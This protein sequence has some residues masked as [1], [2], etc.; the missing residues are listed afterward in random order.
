MTIYLEKECETGFPF[1]EEEVLRLVA[2]K[3]AESENC[4]FSCE[5]S[6]TITDNE[7]IRQLNR[8]FR[9]IDRPT[10]VL[11]FP[12]QEYDS[13]ADFSGFS[14]D[15]PERFDPDSG[16]LMLGDIVISAEKVIEQAQEYGH[17]AKREFAFLAAHSM[18]HLFGYDHMTPEE[19]VVMEEKQEAILSD[20]GIVRD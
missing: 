16:R 9:S 1:R 18:L 2:E 12:L 5:V 3:A 17:S 13:P 7:R 19:A 4:P 10:D 20:L 14:E 8:D 15:D 11:S 6:V